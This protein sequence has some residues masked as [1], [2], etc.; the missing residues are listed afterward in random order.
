[1]EFTRKQEKADSTSRSAMDQKM[2]EVAAQYHS[3][4]AENK[5]ALEKRNS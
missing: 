5:S 4:A 2:Q 3:A 1:M